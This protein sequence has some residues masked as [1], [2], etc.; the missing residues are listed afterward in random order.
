MFR[1]TT[2]CTFST[3]RL[4]KMVRQWCVLCILTSI[5]ASRHSG[6]HF[7]DIATS[8]SG[9]TMVCFVHFYAKCA[10]RHKCF[11][12][13][14][15]PAGSAP[16]ARRFRSLLLTP[17]SHKSL[18]K[19]C[20]SRLS[21]LLAHLHLLSCDSLSSDLLSSNLSLLSASALLCF[22]KSRDG[23]GQR[24][25]LSQ[26]SYPARWTAATQWHLFP[27]L[28]ARVCKKGLRS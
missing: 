28:N 4:P 2:A 9:R 16:R 20:V 25:G 7:F 10:S 14:I 1:A 19:H 3:S 21:Y 26:V 12:S 5:C 23:S 24:I 27:S 11:S 13:L 18:Q 8:K 22:C 6:L 15:W 17:R